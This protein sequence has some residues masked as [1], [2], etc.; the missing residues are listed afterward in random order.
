MK[1]IAIYI[2]G[3][4]LFSSCFEDTIKPDILKDYTPKLVVNSLITAD[5]SISIEITTSVAAI[6]NTFPNLVKDAKI[7]ITD[8]SLDQNGNLKKIRPVYRDLTE[9]YSSPQTF[10]EGTRLEVRIT[11]PDYPNVISTVFI[12]ADVNSVGLLTVDGGIDTGGLVGDLIQ[13]SFAD[14]GNQDNYYRLKVSYFSETVGVWVPFIF[15]KSDPSLAEYNSFALDDLSILFND[16]LFNGQNKTFSTVAP[17]GIVSRNTGDKFRVEF[18]S[19]SKDYFEYYR[20]L[21]RATDAKDLTF[22]GSYNNA[23]VIH[24]N[25]LNGLGILGTENGKAI[26]LK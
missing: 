5:D 23:V 26:V 8:G 13:V 9:T 4:A 10:A 17:S 19:I 16:E 12:P 22:Q 2:L 24:T 25:V 6:D 14:P 20:S 1:K 7:T 15:P 18:T 21:Q 3:T 11:H